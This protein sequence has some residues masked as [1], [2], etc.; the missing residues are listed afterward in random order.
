VRRGSFGLL[1]T[2][3]SA[4]FLAWWGTWAAAAAAG[5]GPV[6]RAAA[7]PAP[8]PRGTLDV[9]V[10]AH[11]EESTL[12]HLLASLAGQPGLGRIVVVAD[13]CSDQTADVARAAGA[14]VVERTSG[15]RGKPAALRDALAWYVREPSTAAGVAFVDADCV[16]SPGFAAWITR[17]LEAT[18]V[19]QVANVVSGG[20]DDA[21]AG[22]VELGMWLRNLLRPAGLAR[23]GV[24]VALSGT[25]FAVRRDELDLIQLEDDLTEDLRLSRELW[26]RG[27]PIGFVPEARVTSDV[28]PDRAGLTAQRERWEGQS[29]ASV[30]LGALAWAVVR[31]RDWRTGVALLDTSAPPLAKSLVAWAGLTGLTGIAVVLRMARPRSLRAPLLAG[32]L[33]AAYLGMGATAA[34]GPAGVWRLARRAPGFLYWKARFYS[35][36]AGMERVNEWQRTPREAEEKT[37]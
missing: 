7:Q 36:H 21:A 5:L 37:I 25:G 6:R 4:P 33:L 10:P 2:A 1:A 15:A 14:H 12:P 29:G 35:G 17:A 30:A 32:G 24:P 18:P 27:I 3:A 11:D 26:A 34:H 16:C 20:D 28:P 9:I 31:R 13:H 8:T 22:G 19:V 23:F